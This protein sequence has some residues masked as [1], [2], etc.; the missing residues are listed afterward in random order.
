MKK[1]IVSTSAILLAIAWTAAPMAA[2]DTAEKVD[3]TTDR[4]ERKI[5]RAADKADDKAERAAD[6]VEDKAER[7]KDKAEDTAERAKDKAD[8][9]S[10]SAMDKIKTKARNAKDKISSKLDAASDRPNED[11]RAAQ[12]ALR[13]KGHNPGPVDGVMGPRTES[14]LRAY[15][16]AE[17]LEQTGRLD[18]ATADKL[19][20]R[21]ATSA[22]PRTDQTA[23]PTVGKPQTR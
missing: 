21:S 8:D 15:Q 16:Q 12:R 22:S 2:A 17:G 11:V 3:R 1:L 6:K 5:D 9:R 10:G 19:A 7:A 13:A 14:A 4:V 23:P 20:V 18:D